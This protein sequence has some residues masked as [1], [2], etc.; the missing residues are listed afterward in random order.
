ME[1]EERL[2]GFRG[3]SS[4]GYKMVTILA[5]LIGSLNDSGWDNSVFASAKPEGV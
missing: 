2:A 4:I 5:F 3:E 1:T